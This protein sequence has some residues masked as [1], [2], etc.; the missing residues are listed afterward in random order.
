MAVFTMKTVLDESKIV[1][2]LRIH[3]IFEYDMVVFKFAVQKF[4]YFSKLYDRL[5]YRV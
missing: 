1:P 5:M 2:K 3:E 4:S